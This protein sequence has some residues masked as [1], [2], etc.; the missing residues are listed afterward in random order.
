VLYNDLPE[1]GRKCRVHHEL[2][3]Q[4]GYEWCHKWYSFLY[5]TN[6][7]TRFLQVWQQKCGFISLQVPLF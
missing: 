7:R 6:C 1:A 4:V 2:R 3:P 5:S